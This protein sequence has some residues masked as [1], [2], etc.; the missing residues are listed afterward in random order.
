MRIDIITLFPEFFESYFEYS[1]LKRA[2]E[3]GK[4]ELKIHNL[5]DHSTNKQKSVDDYQFKH[6]RTTTYRFNSAYE[7]TGTTI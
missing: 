4:A 5:R 3:N 6:F 7:W 1:I 2:Q